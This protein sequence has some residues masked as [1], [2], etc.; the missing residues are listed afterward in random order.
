MVYFPALLSGAESWI[1]LTRC[2]SRIAGTEMRYSRQT[3]RDR[4]RNS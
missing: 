3:R 4:K 1:V 2:E